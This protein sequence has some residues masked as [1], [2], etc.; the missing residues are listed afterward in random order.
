MILLSYP[1][2]LRIWTPLPILI[3]L[4]CFLLRLRSLLQIP[5]LRF[6][7]LPLVLLQPRLS[8]RPL[9]W[10]PLRILPPLPVI[11]GDFLA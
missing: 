6:R 3:L 5:R 8:F 4:H 11:P 9:R 2:F 7:L 10:P 1:R